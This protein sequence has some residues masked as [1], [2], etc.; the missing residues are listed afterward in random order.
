MVHCQAGLLVMDVY[1]ECVCEA[2]GKLTESVLL[3]RFITKRRHPERW[4]MLCFLD[5]CELIT[6]N[7]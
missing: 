3:W 1:L 5:A 2:G 6:S 4:Q 7:S